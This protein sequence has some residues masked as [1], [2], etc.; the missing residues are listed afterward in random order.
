MRESTITKI[1]PLVAPS[2]RLQ[3]QEPHERDEG[4]RI[5]F[6]DEDDI[7]FV[8]TELCKEEGITRFFFFRVHQNIPG[9]IITKFTQ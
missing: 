7:E 1:E 9:R 6:R 2:A 4:G 3:S 5:I 8:L